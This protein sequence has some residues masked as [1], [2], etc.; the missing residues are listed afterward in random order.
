MNPNNHTY[1]VRFYIGLITAIAATGLLFYNLALTITSKLGTIEGAI[2]LFCSLVGLWSIGNIV[3][4][5]V[6]KFPTRSRLA[7]NEIQF[8]ISISASVVILLISNFWK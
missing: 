3:G 5:Y 7:K 2:L 1:D 4:N 6:L 8:A